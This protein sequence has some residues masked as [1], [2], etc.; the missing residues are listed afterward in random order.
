MYPNRI[1]FNSGTHL[2]LKTEKTPKEPP[3]M[4]AKECH[5]DKNAAVMTNGQAFIAGISSLKTFAIH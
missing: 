5:F 2:P 1:I 4:V 3:M